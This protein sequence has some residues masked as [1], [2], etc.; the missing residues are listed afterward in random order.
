MNTTRIAGKPVARIAGA[1]ALAVAALLGTSACSLVAPVAT[2]IQY[3]P[4]DGIGTNLGDVKIRDVQALADEDGSISLYFYVVNGGAEQARLNVS[5]G[6]GGADGSAAISLEP[7]LGST[8]GGPGDDFSIVVS[9][10]TDARLGGL[11]P[12]YFQVGQAEGQELLV[13]VLDATDRP[14]FEDY[15]P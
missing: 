7:G 14:F 9:D 13:P 12:V 4:A 2:M 15:L 10:P 6:A 8:V 1:A 3:D 5:L 11:Y